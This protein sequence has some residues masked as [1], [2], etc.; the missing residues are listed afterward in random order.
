LGR[1]GLQR[2]GRQRQKQVADRRGFVAP[3]DELAHH[4]HA[5]VDARVAF[6]ERDVAREHAEERRLA[7]AV[8]A[9]ERDVLAVADAERH[10]AEQHLASRHA[11]RGTAHFDHRHRMITSRRAARTR[12]NISRGRRGPRRPRTP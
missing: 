5:A 1:R 2:P 12:T 9:D 7:R 3:P 10:V 11:A 6:V 8:R 4:S